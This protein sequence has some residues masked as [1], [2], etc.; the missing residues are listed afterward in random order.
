M[1]SRP[2]RVGIVGAGASGLAVARELRRV[3]Y[4]DVVV[5][6][7]EERV[8]GKC[9][10][11]FHEGRSYELGAGAV[12]GA[13]RNVRAL[14]REEGV[15]SAPGVGGLLVDLDTRRESFVPE[16]LRSSALFGL[17]VEGV[18][19]AAALWRNR[20][21]LDPGFDGIAPALC[22]PFTEWAHEQR[23][24]GVAALVEPWFT[25][26]GYGYLDEVPAAYVLKYLALFRFPV[27]ELLETGYQG[28]W[29]RVA[30][31]LDVRTRVR[32]RAVRRGDEVVVETEGDRLV[33]DAL[34]V[35]CP[36]SRR[37]TSSTPRA[38]SASSCHGFATT[39]TTPWRQRSRTRH[40]PGTA[41]FLGTSGGTEPATWSS[42]IGDGG[43]PTS[44]S[45][46]AC[47]RV[48]QI[49]TRR[50][51]PCAKTSRA[52]AAAWAPSTGGTPGATS[53]TSRRAT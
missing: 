15:R 21:V 45:T 3:G 27:H 12:T 33:F 29:E 17:G 41:S 47:P 11:F 50:P 22:A 35:T 1:A 36:P 39:T 24:E 14:M 10:T 28:L 25:G 40:T 49:S 53:L 4:P 13:Y 37:S 31:G 43:S 8:G 42:G 38:R 5:L 32:V 23:L 52:W 19:L 26:F 48:A 9:A 46:I 30:G 20:R 7:R 51:R 2:P 44:S 18:R 6:E 34:V 16:V